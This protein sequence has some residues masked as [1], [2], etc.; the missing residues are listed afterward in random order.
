MILQIYNDFVEKT[1]FDII[2]VTSVVSI[3]G[4]GVVFDGVIR[5]SHIPWVHDSSIV[6]AFRGPI[7]DILLSVPSSSCSVI[8]GFTN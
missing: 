1:H 8:V 7:F 5:S 4:I 2:G 3:G 6:V